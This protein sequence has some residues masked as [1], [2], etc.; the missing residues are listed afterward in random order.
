MRNILTSVLLSFLSVHRS[1][2]MPSNP[3]ASPAP[4]STD[5]RRNGTALGG[6]SLALKNN[7]QIHE[8]KN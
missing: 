1:G 5:I 8:W 7:P 3:S 2:E 6:R 4:D